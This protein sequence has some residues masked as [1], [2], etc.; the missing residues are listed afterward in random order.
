M[1]HRHVRRLALEIMTEVT[2]VARKE[3]VRLEKVSGT[4]DLSCIALDEQERLAA[5]SPS[6]SGQHGLLPP[7][8]FRTLPTTT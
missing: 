8:G 3:S 4:I 7:M 1:P 5:G 6:L 2:Q